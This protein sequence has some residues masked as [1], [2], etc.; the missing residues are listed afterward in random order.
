MDGGHWMMKGGCG[1]T[2][3][4][5]VLRSVKG[6]RREVELQRWVVWP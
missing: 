4:G 6:G 3:E 5:Q 1:G 2:S